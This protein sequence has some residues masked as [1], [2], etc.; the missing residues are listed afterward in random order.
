MNVA[1][2]VH[3]SQSIRGRRT[4]RVCR[5]LIV[6][7]DRRDYLLSDFRLQLGLGRSSL[8]CKWHQLSNRVDGIYGHY[9][10]D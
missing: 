5:I 8:V 3:G 1:I 7:V 4:D 6:D 2:Q 10:E 9:R